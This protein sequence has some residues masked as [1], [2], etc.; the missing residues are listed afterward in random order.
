MFDFLNLCA[1]KQI[2]PTTLSIYLYH[3]FQL[4]E[5]ST[6]FL[7]LNWFLEKANARVRFECEFLLRV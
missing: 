1:H 3:G 6:I 5:I 4:T 2:T 7:H